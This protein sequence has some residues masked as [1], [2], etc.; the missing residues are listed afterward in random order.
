MINKLFSHKYIFIFLTLFILFIFTIFEFKTSKNDSLN[1]N[2]SQKVVTIYFLSSWS[3]SDTKADKIETILNEFQKENPDIKVLNRSRANDDFLFTLKTDFAQGNE[4][5]VFGLWPGSDIVNLI[6]H[7][8]VADL[9]PILEEDTKWSESFNKDALSYGKYDG[10]VYGL[11][12]EVI[13]EGLFINKD[14]FQKYNVKIPENYD[15]LLQAVKIFK[16]NNIVPIAYN[17]TPEGT[18]LY[19]NIVAKLGGKDNVENPYCN[20]IIKDC[21]LDGMKYMKQLY[22]LG[23]FPKECFAMDDKSRNDMFINKKAAMIVQGSWFIGSGS[24]DNFSTTVGIVPFPYFK[25]SKTDKS[26]I[27]YG[28]GNGNFHMSEAAYKDEHKRRACVKLL[29]FL[30]ST[31]SMN[32]FVSHS[33]SMS[34]LNNQVYV[35]NIGL[36]LHGEEMVE[37]SKELI[38]P[39]D[40]II[41]RSTWENVLVKKFPLMLQNQITPE[42]IYKEMK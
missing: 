35:D 37:N 29:K 40:S 27:I 6:N 9:T 21:Y 4:P 39:P 36:S 10:K 14:L 8:K 18:Y 7:S 1:E 28:I 13:Y 23:A 41:E 24:I 16:A 20:D 2:V 26:A 42:E 5:D 15:E 34:G 11:P 33:G 22:D 25:D 32:Y 17:S 12:V 3:G 30:T 38:A 19:Q 31:K